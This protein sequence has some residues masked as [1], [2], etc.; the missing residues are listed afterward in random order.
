MHELYLN[1]GIADGQ[2]SNALS[3]LLRRAGLRPNCYWTAFQVLT[4]HTSTSLNCMF[5]SCLL[6]DLLAEVDSPIVLMTVLFTLLSS[7]NRG[8]RLMA[9][10][11]SSYIYIAN[12]FLRTYFSLFNTFPE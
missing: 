2:W 12:G 10:P 5:R 9:I 11:T 7:P 6:D 4:P 1:W 3:M 8:A